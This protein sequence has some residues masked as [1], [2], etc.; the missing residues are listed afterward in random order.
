MVR[1]RVRMIISRRPF[2]LKIYLPACRQFCGARPRI[3]LPLARQFSWNQGDPVIDY[4]RKEVEEKGEPV[5]LTAIEGNCWLP[6]RNIRKNIYRRNLIEL[7]FG[8]DF[9]GYDRV[10]D[11]HIKKSS[12]EDRGRFQAAG[13][14]VRFMEW[15]INLEGRQNEPQKSVRSW[16]PVLH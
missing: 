6:L 14:S 8:L 15:G 11:T 9:S 10:I 3:P 1:I 5:A 4:D 2:S 13:L 12:E 7:V 16:R